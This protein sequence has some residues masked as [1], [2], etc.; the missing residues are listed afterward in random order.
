[1]GEKKEEILIN[2][3]NGW[4]FY[5]NESFSWCWLQLQPQQPL[6]SSVA[7]FTRLSMNLLH[8]EITRS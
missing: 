5:T 4:P 3:N 6:M 2:L 7:I 8:K 1:M